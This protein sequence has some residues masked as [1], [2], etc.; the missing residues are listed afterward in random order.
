MKDQEIVD[1]A[2]EGAITFCIYEYG[3]DADGNYLNCKDEFY[4][5]DDGLWVKMNLVDN[6]FHSF[7][8]LTDIKRIVD[9][10]NVMFDLLNRSSF[11][12]NFPFEYDEI[13]ALKEPKT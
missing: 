8:S 5:I 10:E 3:D 1:N 7:R 2:P 9:L 6:D 4:D 13:E 11:A 12:M